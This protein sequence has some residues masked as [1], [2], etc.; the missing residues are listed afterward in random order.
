MT[1]MFIIETSVKKMNHLS[2]WG[3]Y[4]KIR[5]DEEEE[6]EQEQVSDNDNDDQ[7]LVV[8][9]VCTN[10]SALVTTQN[11][12]LQNFSSINSPIET[13]EVKIRFSKVPV[14]PRDHPPSNT[15]NGSS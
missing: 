1:I 14:V 10:F 7:P 4:C 15:K 12:K 2:V 8:G 5:A 11:R 9:R 13:L 3:F 6:Q